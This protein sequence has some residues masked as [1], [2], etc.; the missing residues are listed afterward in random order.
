[1]TEIVLAI[2]NLKICHSSSGTVLVDDLSLDLRLGETLA[3]VGESGSGKSITALSAIRLLPNALEINEGSVTLEKDDIFELTEN[4]MNEVRGRRIAMIFQEPQTSL[5]PVQTVGDQLR[6]V[7]SLHGNVLTPDDVTKLTLDL[8]SEVGIPQPEERINW[9][10]HQLSGGQVQ[11]I[12]IAIALACDPDVLIADEPTTALDVTIQKQVLDLLKKLKVE[13]NLSILFIT[14]DMGVVSAISDRVAVMHNG[15]IIETAECNDFFSDPQHEYSKQLIKSL[16]NTQDYLRNESS[17]TLL[18]VNNLHVWF[19]IKTGFFQRT[20]SQTKAVD[21]INF[22]ID[23]GETLALVGESGCGKTTTGR[24][25]LRLCE[26]TRGRIIFGT[27][28]IHDIPERSY[29]HFRKKIQVIFQDPFSSMNPRMTVGD[30][31]QEG[32]MTLASEIPPKL[33]DQH[34]RRVLDRV[35]L[36]SKQLSRYPHEFSGGQR[37]RIAIARALAVRPTLVICDEPTSA[38]DVSL[39]AEVLGLL[40]DFQTEEGIA[41]LFITHDLSLIPSF[42]H[43]VAVMKEGKIVE[44]GPAENIMLNAQHP[45]SRELIAAAPVTSLSKR[46]AE[47]A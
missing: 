14:H 37:Q 24:A 42:A 25:I 22:H 2:E 30:I 18:R 41:Y 21:G 47:I 44:Q 16:P 29:L 13:R 27:K 45:Y 38:L 6:E 12:M 3:I 26:L 32:V 28:L 35:G 9:Y 8:L 34:I 46:L 40:R 36:H 15:K 19:P 7:I 5:N 4:E 1:M 20:I 43:R 31:I 23:E 17:K 11:R 39:R 10:P 33:R